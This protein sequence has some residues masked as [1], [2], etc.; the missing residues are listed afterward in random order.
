MHSTPPRP[1]VRMFHNHLALLIGT[2]LPVIL[3]L[4]LRPLILGIQRTVATFPIHESI[5]ERI[6][7]YVVFGIGII[8]AAF[9]AHGSHP[10]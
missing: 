8:V 1:P 9:I 4:L 7:I 2:I 5:S 6:F 10:I 3:W